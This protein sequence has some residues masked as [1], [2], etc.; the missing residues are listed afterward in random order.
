VQLRWS[1]E[2][3]PIRKRGAIWIMVGRTRKIGKR[4]PNGQLARAYVNPKAQVAAQPHRKVVAMSKYREWPEA[5]SEFGRLMLNGWITPAQYSAG[6]Q[7]A[8][9]AVRYRAAIMGPS[10]NPSGIDLERR[11]GG[12]GIGME[13]DTARA[14]KRVYDSAFESCGPIRLQRLIAHHVIHDR[15][16]DD[17]DERKLLKEGLDKLVVHFGIDPDLQISKTRN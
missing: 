5:E 6:K 13:D 4:Q 7:Y 16:S 12:K 14:I 3:I 17:L 2:L 11:G 10:P 9:L 8:E 1:K 15:R